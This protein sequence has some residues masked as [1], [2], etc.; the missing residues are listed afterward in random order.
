MQLIPLNSED[1]CTAYIH[2]NLGKKLKDYSS[3][4]QFVIKMDADLFK[5]MCTAYRADKKRKA[6]K[7]VGKSK[8]RVDLDTD[9]YLKLKAYAESSNV[10]LSQALINVIDANKEL[11]DE[12]NS[13]LS[14]LSDSINERYRD[15]V[16]V[17]QELANGLIL[18]D[19]NIELKARIAELELQLRTSMEATRHFQSENESLR[20][21][22]AKPINDIISESNK[23][24]VVTETIIT[25]KRCC[26]VTAKG[27]RCKNETN[28]QLVNKRGAVLCKFHM[29]MWG[30]TIQNE[31]NKTFNKFDY[32]VAKDNQ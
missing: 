7:E 22:F 21:E 31:A 28:L 29:S 32:F 6:D 18:K 16:T 15:D 10:T 5:R 1:F 8:C 4:Y 19:E 13:I 9:S 12:I 3:L 17:S 26:A 14:N 2:N 27:T 25:A 23:R 20:F 30:G 24:D 11:N